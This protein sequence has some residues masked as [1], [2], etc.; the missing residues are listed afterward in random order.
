MWILDPLQKSTIKVKAS[1]NL[2]YSSTIIFKEIHD[3]A[4]FK[5]SNSKIFAF[6]TRLS[7]C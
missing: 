7:Q 3:M 5:M 6:P 2:N 1:L 4:S